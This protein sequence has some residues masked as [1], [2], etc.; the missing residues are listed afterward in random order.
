MNLENPEKGVVW[1]RSFFN[2]KKNIVIYLKYKVKVK[3]LENDL[4]HKGAGGPEERKDG[5]KGGFV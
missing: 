1:I 3:M 4:G 5:Y 2:D